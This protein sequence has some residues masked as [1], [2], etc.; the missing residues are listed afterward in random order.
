MIEKKSDSIQ[1]ILSD[2]PEPVRLLV[3]SK[4]KIRRFL[5][6]FPLF[7]ITLIMILSITLWWKGFT[8]PAG[9]NLPQV[10]STEETK[11]AELESY[12]KSLEASQVSLQ[13][14]LTQVNAPETELWLGPVKKPYALQNLTA[15]SPL[16][17]E[18]V[19]LEDK[20]GKRVIKFQLTNTE[21]QSDRVTGHIFVFQVDSRGVASY[22]AMTKQEW[23]DGIRFNKGES[24][25]V[26]RLRP[27]EA[28]FP[29]ADSDAKFLVIIFNREGDLLIREEL[30]SSKI[31]A[32][33]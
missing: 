30:L 19:S 33:P 14:K 20:A 24:F 4:K 13:T 26:S 2:H 25:A 5:F 29:P 1:I 7:A 6:T 9:I 16:K 27:V 8:L 17:I 23:L 11:I 28:S 15:S 12:I 32:G 22:P 10:P 31:Q 21:T 3:F 18:N